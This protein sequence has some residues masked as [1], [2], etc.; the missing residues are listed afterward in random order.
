M[1]NNLNKKVLD[2][3]DKFSIETKKVEQ[4]QNVVKAICRKVLCLEGKVEHM[5][6][7]NITGEDG[8]ESSM[9][10]VSEEKENETENVKKP[11]ILA[12]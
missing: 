7:I 5:K 1:V 3:I 2:M 9:S 6:N 8:G 11:T 12:L 4:L 10:E